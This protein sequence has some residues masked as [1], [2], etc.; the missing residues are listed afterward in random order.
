MALIKHWAKYL[1]EEIAGLERVKQF[2]LENVKAAEKNANDWLK[3]FKDEER[4]RIETEGK[5]RI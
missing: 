2:F 5:R 3:K 4:R 1:R